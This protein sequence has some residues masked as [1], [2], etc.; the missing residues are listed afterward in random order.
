MYSSEGRLDSALKCVLLVT[1]D[2]GG[3]A[4]GAM[5]LLSGA[6]CFWLVFWRT[7]RVRTQRVSTHGTRG[8]AA[9]PKACSE[10]HWGDTRKG[11]TARWL[12]VGKGVG[13]FRE[14]AANPLILSH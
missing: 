4:I 6:F 7:G 13:K 3:Q 5:M 9:P 2:S 12:N 1:D 8:T 11:A 10:A 14:K